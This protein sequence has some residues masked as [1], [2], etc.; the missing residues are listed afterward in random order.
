MAKNS[1]LTILRRWQDMDFELFYRTLSVGRFAKKHR[2]STKT[3]HRDLVA[4]R[5]LGQSACRQRRT[6]VPK[7]GIEK[8]QH[9]RRFF[10]AA[11]N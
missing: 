5:A 11:V 6:K 8:S 9:F 7:A 10:A 3:V 2:V 1:S 4:F